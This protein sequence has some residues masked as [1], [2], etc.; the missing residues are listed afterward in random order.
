MK[1]NLLANT[2]KVKGVTSQ[3][4][5]LNDQRATRLASFDMQLYYA[6]GIVW[7]KGLYS[8]LPNSY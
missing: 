2:A 5:L 4:K 8:F 7:I 6:E 1:R 3:G